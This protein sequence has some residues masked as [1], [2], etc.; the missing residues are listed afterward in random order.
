MCA[1]RS[2][3]HMEL[4]VATK[5][6]TSFVGNFNQKFKTAG[7]QMRGNNQGVDADRGTVHLSLKA[8]AP[9]LF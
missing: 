7:Y 8:K 2:E 4:Q 5:T 9:P 6:T 3:V 1:D